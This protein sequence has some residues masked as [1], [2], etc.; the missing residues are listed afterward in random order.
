MSGRQKLFRG[1]SALL[2]AGGL[3]LIYAHVLGVTGQKSAVLTMPAYAWEQNNW[4]VFL[5]GVAAVAFALPAAYGGWTSTERV[6]GRRSKKTAVD[7]GPQPALEPLA[8]PEEK[9]PPR[10]APERETPVVPAPQAMEEPARPEKEQE[11]EKGKKPAPERGTER[12]NTAPPAVERPRV[13]VVPLDL[14]AAR[15]ARRPVELLPSPWKD[16][17]RPRVVITH[18]DLHHRE[19]P[20]QGDGAGSRKGG[21]TDEA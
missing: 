14:A 17:G 19:P 15:A 9:T 3:A 5:A 13:V 16:G 18:L 6:P 4:S 12:E 21:G 20:R 10:A 7:R 2:L 1:L 8:E 11:P